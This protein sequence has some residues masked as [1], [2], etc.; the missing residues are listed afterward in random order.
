MIQSKV[1]SNG[2]DVS[3][4]IEGKNVPVCGYITYFEER[5]EYAAFQKVGYQIY[6]VTV[7]FAKRPYPPIEGRLQKSDGRSSP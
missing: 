1:V 5:N 3:L 7:S 4:Q 6:S 2:N